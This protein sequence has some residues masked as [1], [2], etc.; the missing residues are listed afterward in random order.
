MV[1]NGHQYTDVDTLKWIFNNPAP[2]SV[3]TINNNTQ[4][5]SHY[6][7]ITVGD[8]IVPGW[9]VIVQTWDDAIIWLNNNS[10]LSLLSTMPYSVVM[11]ILTNNTAYIKGNLGVCY[12]TGTDCECI[13][14]FDG[15][16]LY[17]T[18]G[19]CTTNPTSCCGPVIPKSY[20]CDCTQ[21]TTSW[22]CIP[23]TPGNLVEG[24]TGKT[25]LN[26]D[27]W[28]VS[29]NPNWFAAS[30][31]GA[32]STT[33]VGAAPYFAD[34]ANGLQ[35]ATVSGY[36][37]IDEHCA[38]NSSCINSSSTNRCTMF[39]QIAASAQTTEYIINNF[40]YIVTPNNSFSNSD[41]VLPNAINY[42]V[43][44]NS[45]QPLPSQG[46]YLAGCC[47]NTWADFI[48]GTNMVGVTYNGNPLTMSSTYWEA[49][50]AIG[51]HWGLSGSLLRTSSNQCFCYGTPA[52]PGSCVEIQ[53]TGGVYT[54]AFYCQSDVNSTCYDPTAIA[55]PNPCNC[56]DPGDGSGAYSSITHCKS[57]VHVDCYTGTTPAACYGTTY[58]PDPVFEQYLETHTQGG[59]TVA[60][61]N[62]GSMGNGIFDSLVDNYRICNVGA[63]IANY[64]SFT[65]LTG[66][67]G[68]T[69][70]YWLGVSNNQLTSLNLTNNPLLQLLGCEYNNITTLDVT[71]N[72]LL[73]SLAC[74]NNNITSIDLT[75]NVNLTI[76]IIGNNNITSIDLSQNT[77]L[78]K[79]IC[80]SIGPITSLDVSTNTLLTTLWCQNNNLTTIDV[81]TNTILTDFSCRSNNLTTID[82]S[83]NTDLITFDCSYNPITN[84]DLSN[85]M[86]LIDLSFRHTNITNID[87]SNNI[88]LIRLDCQSFVIFPN[89]TPVG[90]L[91]SLDVSNNIN[92][93]R[94]WV[95]GHPNM[96][97]LDLSNNVNLINIVCKGNQLTTLNLGG[98][99]DLSLINTFDATG[100]PNVTI[101]VGTT[102]RVTLFNN[103]FVVGTNYDSSANITI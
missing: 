89:N 19:Q 64:N 6:V 5:W 71:N 55:P 33:V 90:L 80:S 102:Q 70:L 40:E 50:S 74:Y 72:P 44:T 73:V 69:S 54:S 76:L 58:I 48:T 78:F 42:D 52:T 87:V 12:C 60:V 61:G 25:F 84:L 7:S 10:N 83:T 29:V 91:T 77:A 56:I 41:V 2:P 15:S 16:G 36:T 67:E 43:N 21:Q 82:V 38:V 99:L 28:D 4:H 95:G 14:V 75:N 31:L 63:V 27:W 20:N 17:N 49:R 81:S 23:G 13:E 100:N 34:P 94:I 66:I 1:N 98:T 22:N 35:Y 101:H 79:L 47:F 59:A 96:T 86:D 37:F 30:A 9:S 85:N 3:C 46:I 26:V 39:G 92:L 24:C 62:V 45:C 18:S 32:P 93:S 103:T 53:G 11:N 57:D 88:D 68:F 51:N 97:T 8:D 65:D